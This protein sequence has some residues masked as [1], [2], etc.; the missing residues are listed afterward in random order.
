MK[1]IQRVGQLLASPDAVGNGLQRRR[2]PVPR[3]VVV[4]VEPGGWLLQLGLLERNRFSR[5]LQHWRALRSDEVVV[6][7]VVGEAVR[8]R[9][10]RRSGV[11]LLRVTS[12]GAEQRNERLD[13]ARS[14]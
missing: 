10:W 4:P 1:R 14:P 7:V 6:L 9:R 12:A 13:V 3:R 11:L 8:V 2:L 5:L